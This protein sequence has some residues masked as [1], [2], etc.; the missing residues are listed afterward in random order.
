MRRWGDED[1][2]DTMPSPEDKEFV[3]KHPV[4]RRYGTKSTGKQRV[5]A[6]RRKNPDSERVILY[7]SRGI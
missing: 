3:S 7:P 6:C 2:K 1:K 5:A 4:L